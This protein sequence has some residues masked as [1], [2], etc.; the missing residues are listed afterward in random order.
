M[1]NDQ[2]LAGMEMDLLIDEKVM[3]RRRPLEYGIRYA[4]GRDRWG[5]S[6]Q[7]TKDKFNNYFNQGLATALLSRPDLGGWSPST[8]IMDAFEVVEV[9]QNRSNQFDMI[10]T[11]E[12]GT[13]FACG[14]YHGKLQ[15]E[16]STA[17]TAPLA[18][19]RAALKA[20]A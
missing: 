10:F 5:Q 1:N 15:A 4:D 11:S 3:G 9:M 7:Y 18:I 13:V 8:N 17:E 20:M 2:M 19:C 16:M 6:E 12:Y 14:F